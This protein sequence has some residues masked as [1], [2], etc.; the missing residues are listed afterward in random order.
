MQK[1]VYV[2]V[3]FTGCANSSCSSFWIAFVYVTLDH[4]LE[5][6]DEMV[7]ERVCE[8]VGESVW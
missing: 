4:F 2:C 6:E 8:I 3:W 1:R 7:G 5:R